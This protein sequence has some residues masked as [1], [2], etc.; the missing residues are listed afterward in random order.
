MQND[1]SLLFCAAYGGNIDLVDWLVETFDLDVHQR[2][3][4]KLKRCIPKA[5]QSVSCTTL[6]VSQCRMKVTAYCGQHGWEKVS[7][8]TI[9]STSTSVTHIFQ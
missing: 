5:Q 6:H 2:T 3:K 8:F 4:V 9:W 7:S 1:W